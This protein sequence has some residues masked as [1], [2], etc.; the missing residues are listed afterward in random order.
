MNQESNLNPMTNL[1][2][3]TAAALLGCTFLMTG[4]PVLAS[5]SEFTTKQKKEINQMIRNYILE[6]PEIL[7]EAIEILQNRGKKEMLERNH[8]R[9]YE[10]GY[11]FVGG[12]ING[13]VTVVEFFDYNCGYCKRALETVERLKKEDGNIKVIYKE[14]PILSETSYTASKAAMAAMKQGKYEVFH[15][16]LLN[17]T[18]SL[19]E[20][21]IFEI[22]RAVGLDEKKLVKDMTSPVLD[23]NLQINRSLAEAFQITGTPAFIIGNE[24]VPGAAPFEQLQALIKKAR[25]RMVEK[26][27]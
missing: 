15:I 20:D 24:I 25:Q 13:D 23:R 1:F 6:N 5:D 27:N 9:L 12:N 14:F 21:H 22:A 3:K 10:D 26:T 7:P 19:T 4:L 16:A 11:S 8:T 17:N 2:K 18:G